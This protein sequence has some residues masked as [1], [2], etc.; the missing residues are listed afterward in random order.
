MSD[1]LLVRRAAVLGAG[2][3]GAQI[4][5]HLVNA[6]VDTVLFDLPAKEGDPNGVVL[7]ALANLAKLSPAPLASKT[8]ADSIVPANYESGLEL[9]QDCDLIIEAI[10]E[11]MDWKQ[12]LYRNIAPFVADHAVLASNTSGLGINTLADVLPEQLRHRFCGVHF[13]NPPRYMH[14]AE[15]IPAK[16]TDAAVLAGLEEFLVGVL[17][18]GVVYARD[19]PNF[20]GNHIGVFSILAT[21]HHTA[22]SGLGFDEV[23]ALT[24]PLIGRPKSA[25]YR[26][27]DVVGLDTMDHVIK[28]MAD[29]LPDDPWHPH[30]KSPPWLGALIAKGALGQKTGGGI[31][32]K[33]GKDI[34]VLDVESQEYRPADRVAAPE[35]VEILKLRD[36][37]EK[38]ARLRASEHPHARFLW[39]MFRDL[40]HYSAFHLAD[41]A[42]TARDVDLA[43]RWGYGWS[44]GPFETWQAAGWKQVADWIAEDI[45]A[46]KT[47]SSAPLPDWVFDGR[48][49]VHAAEGSFSPG[50]N[51]KLPRSALPVYRRQRF[52][53]PLLGEAFV[54][55]E[56]VFEND[57]LRLWHDGDDIAVASFKTKLHTV[58]DHV[59]SGLQEAITIAERQF[60]GMVIWQP[61]EPFSAGADL[62]GAIG[63]LQAGDIQGFDAMV[64]NFQATSQRIKY[65]L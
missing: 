60:R 53:D 50:K 13:F 51:A 3:M 8:L 55:G 15:L 20:I 46:G 41:I 28:T 54:Q 37:A 62:S 39:A 12:D 65:S 10:A 49:G 63:L 23:D 1:K 56:T 27:S 6:G 33:V 4:A 61:K 35:V 16:T 40:F 7:K 5:A 45:V 48:E 44:L 9:L 58:S 29:T 57:G 21:A 22:E 59:L 18:K 14:L 42:E 24:G 30:F 32:R 52:P 26:T 36:P 43:I 34:V 2:V 31:F 38:F 11:R 47:M 17:G 25:T 19:T 64:A